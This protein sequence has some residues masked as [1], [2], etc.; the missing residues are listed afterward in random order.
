MASS[1]DAYDV[2]ILGG[3]PAGTACAI[4]LARG[5]MRVVLAST[6]TA[7][8]RRPAE[9]LS[10]MTLRLI[11]R[12]ALP[13]PGVAHGARRCRGALSVWGGRDE[14]FFDYQI[15]ACGNALM[16]DRRTFDA[17]LS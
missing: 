16:I 4:L 5:G 7:R 2:M 12:L 8:H 3:G 15:Y 17:E 11:R 13:E 14:Q 10:P 6:V 9:V 1:T